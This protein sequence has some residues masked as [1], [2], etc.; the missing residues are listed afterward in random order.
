MAVVIGAGL[1]VAACTGNPVGD[2]HSLR[3]TAASPTSTTPA[4]TS[5][6]ARPVLEP[7]PAPLTGLPD[8]AEAKPDYKAPDPDPALH[9][10]LR[11]ED[12]TGLLFEVLGAPAITINV[13]DAQGQRR[14]SV[15]Q[16]VV[17]PQHEMPFLADLDGTGGEE[18][19]VVTA[20]GG[21]G[22]EE[23]AVMAR[24]RHHRPIRLRGNDVRVSVIPTALP[25]AR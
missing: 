6:Q 8:C 1:V 18:L 14:Q 11:E 7:L 20:S 13:Y 21:S 23:L 5:P 25:N 2:D 4:T 24:E 3:S 15:R 16:Q 10:V 22:G 19:L 9:C 12:R 17:R